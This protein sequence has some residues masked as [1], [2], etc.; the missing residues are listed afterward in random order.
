MSN[1][2]KTPPSQR[3]YG[4]VLGV[5]MPRRDIV[6]DYKMID[7]WE[8]KKAYVKQVFPREPWYRIWGK[9]VFMGGLVT[10]FVLQEIYQ[11]HFYG[12]Q[13]NQQWKTIKIHD[14][15]KKIPPNYEYHSRSAYPYN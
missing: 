9:R 6:E 13:A 2:L 8:W 15:T 11:T 7:T 14:D 4:Q 12:R 1:R 5:K 10:T 3:T